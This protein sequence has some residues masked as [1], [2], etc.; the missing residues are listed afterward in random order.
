[1]LY[2]EPGTAYEIYPS[3]AEYTVKW[4]DLAR[5]LA[6]PAG[7]GCVDLNA[8]SAIQH[9]L[10]ADV[11]EPSSMIAGPEGG[12]IVVTPVIT[13]PGLHHCVI[14]RF[15][16]ISGARGV[17]CDSLNLE[18][19]LDIARVGYLEP[20]RSL[21]VFERRPKV[22]D[23]C[24]TTFEHAES[25]GD[26]VY[27]VVD[28]VE[29]RRPIAGL[30]DIPVWAA[31]FGLKVERLLTPPRAIGDETADWFWQEDHRMAWYSVDGGPGK[32]GYQFAIVVYIALHM[33]KV[34]GRR[35]DSMHLV[36]QLESRTRFRC[37]WAER[38]RLPDILYR[39]AAEELQ[40]GD[41][42]REPDEQ[43]VFALYQIKL[44][45]RCP[46]HPDLQVPGKLG[47]PPTKPKRDN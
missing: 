32:I 27:W 16:E 5:M 24:S 20:K 47:T 44:R 13:P 19:S 37:R 35:F 3:W 21:Y 15:A 14:G 39:E 6:D 2:S 9:G 11:V 26:G 29:A 28:Y 22:Y 18:G 1:M 4:D 46:E 38:R 30:D 7:S 12:G 45:Q 23:H 17:G 10:I 36:A 42:E 25:A 31:G 8:I 43:D 41:P 34:A 33:C 40:R